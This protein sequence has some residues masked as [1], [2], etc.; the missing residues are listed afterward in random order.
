M[1]YILL[2]SL[3][4][5]CFGFGQFPNETYSFETEAL[6]EYKLPKVYRQELIQ[7]KK[8]FIRKMYN[9]TVDG[10][11]GGKLTYESL[12][13]F[14]KDFDSCIFVHDFDYDGDYDILF[15]GERCYEN[16]DVSIY[17]KN[18]KVYERKILGQQIVN[19]ERHA[20]SCTLTVLKK[21]CC[22]D[23]RFQLIELVSKKKGKQGFKQ[24]ANESFYYNFFPE[25]NSQY[26]IIDT[27]ITLTTEKALWIAPDL[28]Q[29]TIDNF[30]SGGE[31]IGTVK[32]NTTVRA[33]NKYVI[34]GISW[35]YVNVKSNDEVIPTK[36]WNIAHFGPI[37]SFRGWISVE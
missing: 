18:K 3:F 12:D 6:K 9:D 22:A 29:E 24:T 14:R 19:L 32:E 15:Y 28:S 33:L 16:P 2:L 7:A 35:Y 20:D 25:N 17:Y 34:N 8:R 31:I 26:S 37:T 5:S 21:P 13:Q 11:C 27:T 23:F 36:F 1:K 30:T 10:M 4:I